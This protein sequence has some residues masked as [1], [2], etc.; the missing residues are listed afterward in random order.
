VI[1]EQLAAIAT[2]PRL[3]DSAVRMAYYL[4]GRDD[5]IEVGRDDWRRLLHGSPGKDRIARDLS[6]LQ[7]YGY[8]ER[9]PGG[10]G[11][12]DSF[13]FSVR[14][15]RTLKDS[16]LVERTLKDSVR[17]DRT[18]NPDSVR[19][20]RTVTR[21]PSSSTP[22][23]SSAGAQA[24]ETT[25]TDDLV[26]ARLQEA[27]APYDEPLDRLQRSTGTTAWAADIWGWYRPASES[28]GGGTQSGDL[29]GLSA[30][31]AMQAL[32]TA[33]GDYASEG[34]P[35]DRRL[36]RG[37]AR[38]AAREGRKTKA[39]RE[40]EQQEEAA[41]PAS[42]RSTTP[43]GHELQPEEREWAERVEAA[44][45]TAAQA[46]PAVVDWANRTAEHLRK[47]NEAD[48]S[49]MRAGDADEFIRLRVLNAYGQK[50][51]DP[52]PNGRRVVG[53]AR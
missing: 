10:H 46:D 28:D 48:V 15:E 1:S 21:T 35:W 26:L 40:R 7:H 25:P 38:R 16:V 50:I 36:F 20:A 45:T 47:L 18:L 39:A 42:T 17:T 41:A 11:H 24:R 32:A 4:A 30:E 49:R 2:D 12:A 52:R 53:G 23:P 9:R 14:V 6:D 37:F 44:L 29:S 43:I 27:L 3:S 13:R 31:E 22:S 19:T 34:K 51:G 8:I 33:I 5:W